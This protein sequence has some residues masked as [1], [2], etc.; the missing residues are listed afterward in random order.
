MIDPFQIFVRVHT[1]IPNRSK[2][3]LR[4]KSSRPKWPAYA[5]VVDCETT[6]DERQTLTF[7]FYRFC[8][9][10]TDGNY[11]CLEEGIFHA[12]TL[13]RTNLDVGPLLRQYTEL[14]PAETPQGYPIR[15]RLLS[16]GE[17]MEQVFWPAVIGAGAVVVSF[18][19]PF[20]LSRL[21]VDCRAAR[22]RGEGWSLVMSL[23]KD[24][25]T[26]QLR[27]NPFQPRIKIKPKDSMA[28]FFRLA[29]V[30][31]RRKKTGK[32]F[33]PYTHGRFLDLRKIG[34]AHV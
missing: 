25:K 6:T 15:L 26:G 34:R 9:R 18:N 21:A 4:G 2:Y 14:H 12:D 29:G 19:L 28:A 27:E 11:I 31:M 20:D 8:R 30:S 24:P 7:G 10:E 23:D 33:K 16:R 13:E 3:Q 5:L 32:R 22:R 1:E 17:F